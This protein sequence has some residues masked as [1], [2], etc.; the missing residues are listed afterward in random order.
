M[1]NTVTGATGYTGWYIARRLLDLGESVINLTGRPARPS[2]FGDRV[3][4]LPFNFENPGALTESLKGAHTLYNTYWVRFSHGKTTF[5]TAV[6]NTLT[7]FHA[8]RDAGVQRIVHTSITNPA[9]DSRLPYF[10]GKAVLERALMESGLSYAI[11]R[12]TVIFGPEDILI[13]NIA[14][15]LRKFP[16]FAVPGDGQYKLQPVYVEDFAGIA[17]NAGHGSENVILDAVG[18]ETFTYDALVRLIAE[19]V[20]S[21]ARI[22]RVPPPVALTFARILGC[23]VKDVVLTR[24][25]LDGLMAG[26]L[27]S[28]Q[29]PL[30][31]TRLTDWL[32]QNRASLGAAYVSELARHFP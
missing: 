31:P 14:W 25:E 30:A 13:H 32:H 8:A 20:G 16:V 17:V 1:L 28:G 11:L 7:L 21:R 5:D 6:R 15:F 12:P 23:F 4:A 3:R 27:V 19:A 29:P 24:D 18:P 26:L 22:V 9:L 10:H 2:P